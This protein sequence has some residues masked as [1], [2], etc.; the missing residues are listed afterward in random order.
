MRLTLRPAYYVPA[1]VLLMFTSV[2]VTLLF[3]SYGAALT[4]QK[5]LAL[6]TGL[7]AAG[8]SSVVAVLAYVLNREVALRSATIEAQKMLLEITSK[9]RVP[10]AASL[11]GENEDLVDMDTIQARSRR[12]GV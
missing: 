2:V 8:V 1:A 10:E 5:A 11:E 6:M 3:S 9:R 7:S 12:R 4:Q